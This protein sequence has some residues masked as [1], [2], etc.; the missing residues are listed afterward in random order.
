LTLRHHSLLRLRLFA[1]LGALLPLAIFLAIDGRDALPVGADPAFGTVRPSPSSGVVIE[2]HIFSVPVGMT[3]CADNVTPVS[4]TATSGSAT[5]LVN[6]G[7]AWT[8][9]QWVG[10]DIQLTSGTSSPQW[11]V[12]TGNT[13]TTITVSEA[14]GGIVDSGTAADGSTTT[15]VDPP[16]STADTGTATSGT[17]TTITQTGA[18]WTTNS[19]I[20]MRLEMSSLGSSQN[21]TIAS[22][23]SD[24]IT[25]TS[26]WPTHVTGTATSATTTTLVDTSK[27]WTENQW[28]TKTV[29]ITSGTGSGQTRSIVSNTNNTLT[30]NSAWTT[31]PDATSQYIVRDGPATGTPFAVKFGWIGNEFAGFTLEL[32]GLDA[33]LNTRQIVSNTLDTLTVTPA[34]ATAVASN[35]A[36]GGTSTTLTDTASWTTDAFANKTV[37][38]L[39]GAASGQSRKILSNTSNTLTIEGTW[40]T[41]AGGTLTG[42]STTTV[43]NDASK[44]WTANAFTGLRLDILTGAQAGQ[45]RTISSNTATSVTVSPALPGA[46]GVGD[47]YRILSIPDSSS[48]YIVRDGPASNAV[49]QIKQVANP[50]SGTGYELFKSACRPGGFDITM[51]YNDAKFDV[52]SDSGVSTGGNTSTTFKDTTKTW[53]VNQWAGSRIRITGGTGTSQTRYVVSNTV[54]TLTVSP[55]WAIPNP[56]T[57]SVY[58]LGGMTVSN[59]LESSGRT[60]S[61][62]SE[63]IFGAGTGQLDCVTL[64]APG[65]GLPQGPTGTG[66]LV[67]VTFLAI[68]RGVST[69][70]LTSQIL[71]LDSTTIPADTLNG[72]RRVIICPDSAPPLTPDGHINSGDFGV[73]SQ[74]FGQTTGGPLFTPQKDPN[75]DGV[76]NSGDLGT[77]AA[78]FGKR[79]I[80]P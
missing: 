46:P 69:F 14:W 67:N 22:N 4:G 9:N 35:P 63:A 24:T 31:V 40:A 30:I 62:P 15:L 10:Y 38:I 76:I 13:A 54:D 27:S 71:E 68:G 37:Q 73:T 28:V 8:S 78:V 2:G 42:G 32:P 65:T 49:F 26:A 29:Q 80:Q 16:T 51:T 34:W 70:S 61:C 77:M 11:R 43:L 52:V 60:V 39:S 12:V 36:T 72:T 21:R 18:G 45:S 57:G 66:N 64:G 50:A 55:A 59:F 20:G 5:T 17:T 33:G 7:A 47:T 48:N 23:T 56:T 44:T 75:E 6:A 74:A 1:L 58:Q 25:V 53:K 3:T 19:F 41:T 79:C